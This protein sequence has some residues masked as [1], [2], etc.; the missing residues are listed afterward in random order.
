MD[1]EGV[2]AKEV[3]NLDTKKFVPQDDIPVKILKL[4]KDIPYLL[5]GAPMFDRTPPSN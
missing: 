5:E 4:D 1:K 2:I 3:K